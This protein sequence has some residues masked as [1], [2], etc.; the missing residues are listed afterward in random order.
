[1]YRTICAF[2]LALTTGAA[3]ATGP[4]VG[5]DCSITW[6]APVAGQAVEGYRLFWGST[7]GARD[8][9][10][11][12]GPATNSTCSTAGV[13]PGQ[14]FMVV[15]AFNIIGESPDSNEFPFVLVTAPP[16]APTNLLIAP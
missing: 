5:P 16:D 14:Q 11:E 8:N 4:I 3:F 7:P 12:V 13:A 9:S 6:D 2:A 1:M 15:R 10:F